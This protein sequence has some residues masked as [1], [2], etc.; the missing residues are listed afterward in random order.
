[1]SALLIFLCGV[2]DRIRGDQFHLLN[3]RIFD[4]AAY[5]WVVAALLGHPFDVFT[6]WFVLLFGLGMSFGWGGPMGCYL[7][8]RKME[9]DGERWQV[10]F[11]KNNVHAALWF[12]GLLWGICVLPL[13]YF[14]T[15]VYNVSLAITLA[16]PLSLYIVKPLFENKY[17]AWKAGEYA[18]GWLV[19]LFTFISM[20]MGWF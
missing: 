10:G 2:I 8:D 1:M 11:L 14:D 6:V 9:G 15:V 12:R 18:R 19:G 7:N 20:N 16:F 3:R 5:G 17:D 4:K 13:A